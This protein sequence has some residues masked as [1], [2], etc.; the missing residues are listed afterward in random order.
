M[1]T[2]VVVRRQRVKL[3]A[4]YHTGPKPL[5]RVRVRNQLPLHYATNG[6]NTASGPS[7]RLQDLIH[8][9]E[10]DCPTTDTYIRVFFLIKAKLRDG[11]LQLLLSNFSVHHT[12]SPKFAR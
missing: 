11:R 10:T 5:K 4:A 12:Q 2:I 1:T 8:C 3:S 7:N 6:Q 9:Q